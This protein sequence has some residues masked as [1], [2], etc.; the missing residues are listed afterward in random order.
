MLV[1][2]TESRHV[3]PAEAERLVEAACRNRDASLIYK[4]TDSTLRGNIGAELRA[5]SRCFPGRIAYVAAYPALGRTVRDG[6]VYVHGVSLADTAFAAD[7]LNPV[8]DSRVSSR[9]D[10]S[11][12]CVVFDGETGADIDRP[13]SIL[14]GGSFRIVAGPAAIAESLA[15]RLGSAVDV[16]WPK[17]AELPGGERQ[18]HCD[19]RLTD[20]DRSRRGRTLDRSRRE[21]AIVPPGGGSDADP[22]QVALETGRAVCDGLRGRDGAVVFGGDT[23]FGLL[24]CLG[25]PKLRPIG[26]ILP[27]VAVSSIEGRSTTLIT[28]AGGFGSPDLLRQ[29]EK[30]LHDG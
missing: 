4:K 17:V 30:R 28:K 16:N 11:C 25:Q 12:D 10:A 7:A 18:P 1:I 14:A 8:R 15:R 3:E 19:F 20:C 23:A 24:Q 21:L 22:L 9:I 27:G 5:L 6:I 29:L 2:D 26:E 13:P